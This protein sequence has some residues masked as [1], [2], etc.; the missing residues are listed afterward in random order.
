MAN[1]DY[2]D[3]GEMLNHLPED[4]KWHWIHDNQSTGITVFLD[5]DSTYAQFMDSHGNLLDEDVVIDFH[6]YLGW[7][8]GVFELLTAFGIRCETV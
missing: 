2:Q 1:V 7:T 8:E 6:N 4:E 5:N 3:L